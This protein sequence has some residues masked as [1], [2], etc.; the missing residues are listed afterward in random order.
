MDE[1]SDALLGHHRGFDLGQLYLELQDVLLN[2]A[3]DL[4]HLPPGERQEKTHDREERLQ[5]IS[6]DHVDRVFF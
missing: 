1:L 3:E 6:D 5:D 2:G 4:D